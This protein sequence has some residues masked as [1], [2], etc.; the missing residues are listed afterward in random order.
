MHN[1]YTVMKRFIF[2]LLSGLLYLSIAMNA[3][4]QKPTCSGNSYSSE[5]LKE[6]KIS[7]TCIAYEIKVSYD[8]TRAFGLSH[9][10]IGIPCGEIKD[11]SNSA[12][13]PIVF[14]KDPTTGVYGLKIDNISGFGGSGT[15]SFTIQFTWC[16]DNSCSKQV[17]V[18]SYK[19]GQCVDY[20]TLTYTKPTDP[21]TCSKLTATLQKKN[22]TCAGGADGQLDVI[23]QSGKAPLAYTWSTGATTAVAQNLTEGAYAVTVIDASGNTLT[24]NETLTAPQP[25]AITESLI[26]PSCNGS[27]NGSIALTASG[28]S[29]AYFYTWSNG[30]TLQNLS[31]LSGGAY[32]VTVTDSQ[33]CSAQKS[34]TLTNSTSITVAVLFSHPSCGQANGTIDITPTGGT[35]P[36]SYLWSNG[37]TTQDLQNFGAGTYSVKI[38][39]AAGCYVNQMYALRNISTL[40]LSFSVTPTQ[41]VDNASGAIDLIVRGGTAPYTYLWQNGATTEDLTGLTE[42]T[43]KVTVSDAGGCSASISIRVFKKTFLVSSEVIEIS[44]ANDLGSITITPVDG[45]APYTYTWSNGAT[46]NSISGLTGGVYTVT[47]TDGSGCSITRTFVL[48]SPT[49]ISATSAVSNSQC[50]SEGAYSIDLSVSGGS[51][52]YTYLWFT[53]AATEDVM[54]LNSGTYSVQIADANGCTITKDVVVSTVSIGWSCLINQ[55][56]AQATCGAAGNVLATSITDAVGY[57]WSVSSSDG[58]WA[59][60]AGSISASIIYTAGSAGS[61]ATFTLAITKDGCTQTCSYTTAVNG[62]VLKD[63]TGGGDPSVDDPCATP[64]STTTAGTTTT[65]AATPPDTSKD[66]DK[67][68]D[69]DEDDVE[70]HQLHVKAYPNPFDEKLNFEWTAPDNDHVRIELFDA[71]GRRLTVLYDGEVSAKQTYA[72]DWNTSNMHDHLCFYRYTSTKEVMHGKLLKR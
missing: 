32:S 49:A 50:G 15:A 8:G 48:A 67:D 27:A 55:P 52:P 30:S 63:N 71:L 34:F 19:A 26:N 56:A 21:P 54:S 33:G 70:K 3:H 59:I 37:V 31:N 44:C 64:S 29:G 18:V 41:C 60:T 28:G 58:R 11:A 51:F 42:G 53:G 65:S 4:A 6:V 13:W 36:Y 39:D 47:I 40:T 45:V 5:I 16:G 46:G 57:L 9:F 2:F 62:C 72:V 10:V 61:N 14:G 68:T 17:G 7:E 12:N 69:T 43:Y 25:V 22:V 20:D 66:S 24:L 1:I 23:V 38:T 35:A